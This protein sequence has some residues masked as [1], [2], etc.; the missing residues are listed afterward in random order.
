MTVPE[1]SLANRRQT[2][3]ADVELVIVALPDHLEPVEL[4]RTI[5][6]RYSAP[7]LVISDRLKVEARVALLDAGATQVIEAPYHPA[8][9]VARARALRRRHA[10]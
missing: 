1:S 8:E 4:I 2:L 5:G 7:I 10:M 3:A 9:L 6:G